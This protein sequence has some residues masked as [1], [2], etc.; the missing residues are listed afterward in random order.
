MSTFTRSKDPSLLN[1]NGKHEIE[2][3]K[4]MED[5]WREHLGL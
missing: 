5:S 1:E 4:R 3:L 2:A